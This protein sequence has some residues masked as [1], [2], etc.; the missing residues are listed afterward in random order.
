MR[1][2][3]APNLTYKHFHKQQNK[4]WRLKNTIVSLK[5]NKETET[6]KLK[7]HAPSNKNIDTQRRFYSTKRQRKE[8]AKVRLCKPTWEE[9]D[10]FLENV[11]WLGTN[12]KPKCDDLEHVETE[13]T[14]QELVKQ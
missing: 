11:D 9:K 2:K 5:K 12:D 7:V 13:K 1:F 6:I 14:D 4:S 3:V 8:K 10:N